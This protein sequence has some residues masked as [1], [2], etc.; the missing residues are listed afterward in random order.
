[1]DRDFP[2]GQSSVD[3]EEVF[4]GVARIG[5]LN[6]SEHPAR[7]LECMELSPELSSGDLV[8]FRTGCEPSNPIE[9]VTC[10]LEKECEQFGVFQIFVQFSKFTSTPSA[11]ITSS[12]TSRTATAIVKH[13][14]PVSRES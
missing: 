2:M 9:A 7:A 13:G 5:Y 4:G 10:L 1:M 6:Q 11:P 3:L 12:S 14:S 8:G